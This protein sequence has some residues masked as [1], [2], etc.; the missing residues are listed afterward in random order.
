MPYPPSKV[1]IFY[2]QQTGF[3][4]FDSQEQD[5]F[6][7]FG[8]MN[9]RADNAVTVF[10]TTPKNDGSLMKTGE[11]ILHPGVNLRIRSKDYDTGFNKAEEIRI[12]LCAVKGY[13]VVMDESTGEKVKIKTFGLVGG[14]N[15]V[16]RE[17]QEERYVFTLNGLLS[18]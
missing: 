2:L 17:E 11:Y 16:G 18:F 10:D 3:V 12:Q 7:T 1:L 5:W 14:V 8:G 15:F 4:Q 9:D 6:G 13:E